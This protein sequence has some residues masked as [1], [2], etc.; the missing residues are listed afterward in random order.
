MPK[1]SKTLYAIILLLTLMTV[2]IIAVPCSQDSKI[3]DISKQNETKIAWEYINYRLPESL[4]PESYDIFFQL[5]SDGK[6]FDGRVTITA[7]VVETTKEIKLHRGSNLIVTMVSISVHAGKESR[8]INS[9]YNKRTEIE[10]YVL[11]E[12]LQKGSKID[13]S[14]TYNGPLGDDMLGFYRSTYVDENGKERWV[15]ATQFETKYARRAFPCFDEPA[16]KA[17]FTIGIS[18]SNFP[19]GYHC[20]SNMPLS[21]KSTDELCVFEKSV[22]MST[23][24]VAF[25]ISDF[26]NKTKSFVSVW[27][28]PELSKQADYA[29]DIALKSMQVLDKILREKYPIKKMDLV[30]V[31]DFTEYAGAMENYGILTF[32]EATL[33]YDE[34]HT[35]NEAQQTIASVIVHECSHMWF[36]NLVTP[37]SWRFIWLSEAFATYYQYMVT[38]RCENT[39]QME[40]QFV[41]EQHQLAMS[42]D[43]SEYYNLISRSVSTQFNVVENRGSLIYSKGASILRM[44]EKTFG[45]EVFDSALR[46]YL[47]Q[48]KFKNVTPKD[49]WKALQREIDEKLEDDKY[50][51]NV[52]ECMKSW[53][54]KNGFPYVKVDMKQDHITLT[55]KRF[56]L[57]NSTEANDKTIW[58]IPITWIS[59]ASEKPPSKL[60]FW[61]NQTEITVEY[62]SNE[63]EWQIFNVN[64]TGFYRVLYDNES[65]KKIFHVLKKGD[66]SKIP[67]LN[68]AAI[69]DDLLNFARAEIVSYDIA[70]SALQ[71]LKRETEYVPFKSAF[72]SLDYLI[73]K[74]AASPDYKLFKEYVISLYS[75]I[76][77]KLTYDD[78]KTDGHL[79]ILLR[80]KINQVALNI[81]LTI[82]NIHVFHESIPKNQRPAAYCAAIKYGSDEDWEFLYE[83]Y[84]NSRVTTEQLTILDALGCTKNTSKLEKYLLNVLNTNYTKSLIHKQD[85]STTF[86]AVYSNLEGAEYILEFIEKH[87]KAIEQYYKS[88]DEIGRIVSGVLKRYPIKKFIDRVKQM[89]SSNPNHFKTVKGLMRRSINLANFELKWFNKHSSIIIDWIK[90]KTEENTSHYRLPSN[91]VPKSYSINLIPKFEP[92]FIFEGRVEIEAKIQV[93]TKKIVLHSDQLKIDEKNLFIS[94]YGEKVEM[95]NV[96]NTFYEEQ[97]HFYVIELKSTLREETFINITITYTGNLNTE[98]RGFYRSSYD[99]QDKKRWLAATHLEPV[100]ARRLFPCFDE[101]HLKATFNISVVAPENYHVLSNTNVKRIENLLLLLHCRNIWEFETTPIMSTYLVAVVVSDFADK[102]FNDTDGKYKVWANPPVVNQSAYAVSV[103]KPIVTDFEKRFQVKYHFNKLDMVALPDFSSGAME[104]IGLITFRETNMLYDKHEM[105]SLVAK[106]SIRNVIAHEIAHQWFG[107]LVSPA[108]WDYVWLSEGFARYFQYFQYTMDESSWNLEAQFVVDHLHKSL[109]TDG[110]QSTHPITYKVYAPADIRAMFDTISYAKAASII[111]MLEKLVGSEKFYSA[112]KRYLETFQFSVTEPSSL[113]SAFEKEAISN[114]DVKELLT[115]WTTQSGFPV[116][117]VYVKRNNVALTQTRF[118][119]KPKSDPNKYASFTYLVPIT[120]ATDET[121]NFND[122]KNV[123]MWFKEK[124]ADLTI[125]NADKGWLIFN[126]QQTGFYR[127]NY[128]EAAWRRIFSVLDSDNFTCIHEINRAM[129]IDDLF[130]LARAYQLDYDILFAGVKYLRHET[131][132]VPWKAAKTGFSY[133]AKRFAGRPTVYNAYR[134]Y[135]IDLLQP[136]FEKLKFDDNENDKHTDILLRKLVLEWMCSLDEKKCIQKAKDL[137]KRQLFLLFSYEIPPNQKT[138]AYCTAI[139]HGNQDDWNYLK[140]KLEESNFATEKINIL[141]ALGCSKTKDNLKLLLNDVIKEGSYVRLQDAQKVFSYVIDGGLTG[142]ETALD[143]IKENHDRMNK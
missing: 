81:D 80:Q 68:R 22:P 21:T 82:S 12:A 9:S 63:I 120:Y 116:I 60:E 53:T 90:K 122:T 2:M 45:S 101:P 131:E 57:Y 3:L 37:S 106:Q 84:K 88:Y 138:F 100:A 51:I 41:I 16:W 75:N 69:V 128:D 42:R 130:N 38:A 47:Q 115:N 31:P 94:S 136:N 74:F 112:L 107:N 133:L 126:V 64:S 110:L 40:E 33:L 117:N 137:F 20:L 93:A 113:F 13:I 39:W 56:L 23:Y 114:F 65:W 35:T 98:M 141:T 105:S 24:L 58:H 118:F 6:N 27:T 95:Y 46:K 125:P 83:E 111:R 108:R 49:L 50:R 77:K 73:N 25:V 62:E 129:I 87:F 10:T 32:R 109:A 132:Y 8:P 135:I 48:N 66:I 14:L 104:N 119:I 89:M 61:L 103:M 26:K 15:A 43:A 121:P 36:G 96:I 85:V 143:F 29:V 97:Y 7:Q 18:K 91:I 86:S 140:K 142:V 59:S 79:D 44:I 28:R 71:Y 17:N 139:R 134:K 99:I 19:K 102:K 70:L 34:D 4:K 54:E 11:A 124:S 5:D 72:M 1:A 76:Y 55:Q 123:R 92:D 127:V 52:T 30:A 67:V 78:S